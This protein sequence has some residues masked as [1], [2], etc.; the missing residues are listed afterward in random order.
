MYL[1][2][3][4]LKVQM[5]ETQCLLKVDHL[6]GPIKNPFFALQMLALPSHEPIFEALKLLSSSISGL[7]GSLAELMTPAYLIYL[8]HLD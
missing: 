7:K 1:A 4:F 8:S 5:C 6:F 2:I 3:V